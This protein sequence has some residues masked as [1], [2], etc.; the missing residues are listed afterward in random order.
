M[1][2]FLNLVA[3]T[4][5]SLAT[6]SPAMAQTAATSTSTTTE[7]R[8]YAGELLA[9]AQS[10]S[11]I[12]SA[13]AGAGHDAQG[14][15]IAGN[16]GF[17]LNVGGDLQFR[18]TANFGDSN[19][20]REDYEGGFSTNLA[21]L[22]FTGALHGFDY[23]VTGAF[24]NKRQFGLEE[25]FVGHALGDGNRVQFG[26]FQL[27]FLREQ[28]VDDRFQLAAGESIMSSIFGQGYS[29]GI[30]AEF[31][32]G[33]F[34][35]IGAFSDGFNTANTDFNSPREQDYGLTLRA[36]W[37]AMGDRA[38]FNDF[39][40]EQGSNSSLLF[41]AGGHYEDGDMQRMY[42]YTADVSFESGGFNAFA[43]GVGRNIEETGGSSFD[44]FGV[45]GQAGYRV[46]PN[47]ELF[48]RYDA[49]FPD[50]NRGLNDSYSF[51]TAGVNYY[52]A[53]HAA[54][55]TA[56]AVYALDETT[57]LGSLGCFSNTGLLGSQDKGE[58]AL[59][60]QL[61]MPF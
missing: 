35:L 48:G 14:F 25:A 8:S 52:L 34:R 7:N 59:R 13:T 12:S 58:I 60:L 20:L 33:D 38:V 2:R 61:Q 42:T 57:G 9:D 3:G 17:R 30:Q 49:I 19:S 16:D 11:S 44:D 46:T 54:K 43:A 50:D 40:S 15:Y 39:T 5:M 51:V 36:E 21:R 32:L 1:G 45:V 37:L 27:P 6:L 26:Q 56:D 29:Q 10:R 23:N 41:G 24:R 28:N 31:N 22:R 4:L 55:F 18:Y 47:V 53:G